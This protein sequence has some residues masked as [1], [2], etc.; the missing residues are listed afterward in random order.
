MRKRQKVLK[1]VVSSLLLVLTI[2][3]GSLAQATASRSISPDSVLPGGTFRVTVSVTANQSIMGLGLDENVP[4][5]WSVS[6]VNNGG[7]T[8]S[9]SETAWL[10]LTANAGDTKTVSYDVTV[11]AGTT[12]GSYSITGVVKSGSPAFSYTVGGEHSVMVLAPRYTLTIAVSG[13]GSTSPSVGTH[14]YAAGTVVQLTATPAAGWL[15]DHWSGDVTGSTNPISI[16]MNGNKSVTAHFVK[17]QYTVTTAVDPAGVG[18]VTGG[19]T[20]D[21]GDTATLQ[22]TATD[23]SYVFDHWSGDLSGST[24][25]ATL[26]VDGDKSVTAHF[27][28]IHQTECTTFPVSGWV[29]PSIPLNPVGAECDSSCWTDGQAVIAVGGSGTDSV[30]FGVNPDATDGYDAGFDIP[31]PPVPFAPYTYAYFMSDSDKFGTDIRAPLACEETKTWTFKVQDEG[32]ANQITLSWDVPAINDATECLRSVTLTDQTTGEQVDMQSVGTYT[33]TKVSD[34]ETRQFTV[35]VVCHC[36]AGAVFGNDINPVYLYQYDPC[37]KS[38]KPVDDADVVPEQG[39]WLWVPEAN[40]EV[41]VTGDP[42]EEDVSLPL[43]CKGWHQI[44]APWDYPKHA[45]LFNDGTETKTWE[46]AVA[47]HWIEDALWQ[48]DAEA[49]EYVLIDGGDSLNPWFGYWLLT[50]VNDL[51]VTFE[52]DSAGAAPMAMSVLPKAAVSSLTPPPPPPPLVS[53]APGDTGAE[54]GLV[55]YNEPNPVRD[56][57]T[58]T[59]KVKGAVPIDAIKVEI[60]DLSGRLVFSDE[61]PGD[62]LEW[63]TENNYG[64]YLANG[65]YLYRVSAKVHGQWVVVQIRKLAIVR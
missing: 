12:P 33:Y 11:P 57:H 13:S 42:V 16:T 32:S 48:Y 6:P 24:N 27:V 14:T 65:V 36:A 22:A 2:S 38:Y 45:I 63:H 52:Y 47:A 25:P 34:P 35:T 8:Y 18:T 62:Q 21:C 46:E 44:S 5:G 7:G 55:A 10:W 51:T 15:F 26:T 49:G 56:V 28:K 19:G 17:I 1:T 60:F 61:Q 50:Y 20:Y 4:S 30:T 64:E 53:P 40:T 59:F 39:Y 58:T 43:G 41:C 54:L 9:S 37:T 23:P 29:M 3:L 31:K